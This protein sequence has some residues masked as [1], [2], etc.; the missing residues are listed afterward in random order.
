MRR[1]LRAARFTWECAAATWWM[2]VIELSLRF[3]DLP[4]TCRL[5]RVICDL[6]STTGPAREPVELPPR[7]RTPVRAAMAVAGC[8]PGGNTCLRQCL[9]VGN[10]LRSLCPVLRIGVR[11]GADAGFSAHSWLEVDGRTLDPGAVDF[12]VLSRRE[13]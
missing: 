2:G 4:T 10:R 6:Q 5:L 1:L 11:R 8:W 13:T 7:T 12:A 3:G 9:L